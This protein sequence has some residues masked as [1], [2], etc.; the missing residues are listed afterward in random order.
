MLVGS[1]AAAASALLVKQNLADGLAFAVTLI[2]ALGVSSR[3]PARHAVVAVGCLTLGAAVPVS[4]AL[5]W[6][7][8]ATGAR[9]L[10]YSMYGFRIASSD[11]LF[12]QFSPAQM[13][14][15][16]ELGRAALL[17]G[18]ALLIVAA[19]IPLLHRGT[20]DAVTVA[21]VAML[22]IEV[23][24]VA[25]GGYYWN[26]YLI[27]L[28]P[29]TCLLV[30]RA[31]GTLS[32]PFMLAFAV[33]VSMIASVTSV[34]VAATQTKPSSTNEVR[35][36]SAWLESAKRPGD[37]AVVLYG[38]AAIFETTRLRPAYPFLWTLPQRVLDPHLTR[39]TATMERTPGPTFVVV[40]S[41]MNP[42]R[43][44]PHRKIQLLLD[45]RYRLVAHVC[46]D[47]VYVRRGQVRT[48]RSPSDCT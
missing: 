34:A 46:D 2:L 25:G 42:S 45:Q 27:A 33:A 29:A 9:G 6:S 41:S 12:S 10:W 15:L 40:R 23:A 38:E 28:V 3:S 26:H 32:R 48:A 20:R 1:G 8:T 39:L 44:E 13:A 47:S 35:A 37:S 24:G 30:G 22:V 7:A 17:S 11:A 18:L 31:A 19:L 43:Q 36:L 5:A 16:H 21:L 4:A 14:R